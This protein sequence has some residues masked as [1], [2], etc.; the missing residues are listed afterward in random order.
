L[1]GTEVRT[2]DCSIAAPTPEF[3]TADSC[4]TAD[5]VVRLME[6]AKDNLHVTA[7]L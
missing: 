1:G 2:Y 5:E 3:G 6:A 7:T 4:L